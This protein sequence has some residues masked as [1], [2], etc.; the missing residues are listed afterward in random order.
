MAAKA[1]DLPPWV[2]GVEHRMHE[3]DPELTEDQIAIAA[4]YGEKRSFTDGEWIWRAGDQ[5][6]GWF[7]VL[8][9]ALEIVDEGRDGERTIITHKRGHYGGEIVTMAGQGA[10]VSGRAKG[11]LETVALTASQLRQ[12]LA[13]E[14]E[15]SEIL[16]TSFI[17]RRMR[18]LAEHQGSITL[19]GDGEESDTAR[20]RTFLARH[21]I[22]HHHVDGEALAETVASL[23]FTQNDLPVL[24]I[25]EETLVNSSIRS[26]AEKL[27]IAVRLED[28]E[29]FDLIVL[30]AGPA[31][32]AS[33]VYGAS[34]GLSVLVVESLAPGGQ[35]GT[36]SRIENYLG[37]PT[38]ISGQGLAGRAFL[39]ATKFGARI[40]FARE[41][42]ALACDNLHEVILDGD[43]RVRG[44]HVV[45]ATGAVYREPPIEGLD[46]FRGGGVH[47]GASFMEAQLCSG[48][49]VAIIG[50]GNS[51]GQAAIFL[52]GHVKSVTIYIRG[53]SLSDSMSSYLIDRIDQAANIS[54]VGHAEVTQVHG[55]SKLTGITVK[56]RQTGK[57]QK[58][59]M[60]H[61]FIFIGAVP[62]S[63]FLPEAIATDKN[64][65]IQTGMD[66]PDDR[67]TQGRAPFH[68]ETSCP[69][70]FAVGDVRSGSVKRV[71]SAVGEGSVCIQF[72]HQ[73]MADQRKHEKAA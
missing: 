3:L 59:D 44:R 51:A 55:D 67:W 10:V 71:A 54:V 17:V 13:L 23:D 56:D 12:L 53:A 70:V 60:P 48:K 20:L 69:G 2:A 14:S 62:A 31:G 65:F 5:D 7:L 64:G 43:E 22:P 38:G 29:E 18:M 32:L 42:T 16:I 72:V 73:L 68:L 41:V 47:Y 24:T 4:S 57:T 40:A 1:S 15:L 33:A 37:F 52:A 58:S 21:G 28:N 6:A 50:G 39:Q 8:S 36:S 46:R 49:D 27:G 26:L 19:Y 30:G 34:E 25:G 35:A 63:D 45:I 61:L 11:T 66:I 9:G